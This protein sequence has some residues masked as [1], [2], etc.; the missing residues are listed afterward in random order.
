MLIRTLEAGPAGAWTKGKPMNG[1][2]RHLKAGVALVLLSGLVAG[3]ETTYPRAH[4]VP[5]DIPAQV[6]SG[7]GDSDGDTIIDCYDRCPNTGR[8][9]AVDPDGCPLPPPPMEP[10]PYRG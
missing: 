1:L 7:N 3:C 2:N 6:C 10:K 5:E 4:V 8:G 9:V